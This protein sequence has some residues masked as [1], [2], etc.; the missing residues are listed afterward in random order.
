[1]E[2][3]KDLHLPA[4]LAHYFTHGNWRRT[5][6][7]FMRLA[8][9]FHN[10]W[11]ER[12][13]VTGFGRTGD[14]SRSESGLNGSTLVVGRLKPAA[15]RRSNW[16]R[17]RAVR[18]GASFLAGALVLFLVYGSARAQTEPV[19]GWTNFVGMP[20]GLGSV[21]GTGSSA[22]FSNPY[23]V[24][25]DSAGNVY[26][27]DTENHTIRKVT[28]AGLV[29]TLAG[30]AGQ[31]GSA[32]GTGSAARFYVPDSVAVDS[33]GNVYVADSW[34]ST[35]RK[36]TPAGEVT[37]LAGSAG[38]VGSADGTGSAARFDYPSGV[39]VDNEGNVYAADYYNSTI[40]KVT[41]GGVVTTLAGSA[42]QWGSAD[43]IGSAA[44]FDRP[45]GVAVDSA[46]NV[47]VADMPNCTIR[48]VTAAG[49]VT[50]LAGSPGQ[51]GSAD[52]AG[53]AA[54][55]YFPAG[56]A[57]DS[58]GNV[59]VADY[60]NSTIRKVT[61][62]GVVTTLAGS[63][64]QYGSADGTGRAARFYY[65]SGVAV[66]STG[67]VYV[68]DSL[69]FA[70]PHVNIDRGNSTIRK[71]TPAG[72]VTTLAGSA[73]QYGSADG[74]GSAARFNNPNGVAVDSAG[75]VYVADIFNATIRKVTPAGAV[76][77][78]A[79][80][81]GQVGS[82][83]GIGSAARFYQPT[84]VAVDSAGNVYVA[85]MASSTIRKV[86]PTGVVTT[87]AGSAGQRGSADGAGSEARF[88]N[89]NGV[90]V[91]S[92]GNVYVADMANCTIRK[93]TP[94][95]VVTTIG[96]IPGIID[97]ADG[98]GSAAGFAYPSDIAVDMAGNLYVTDSV[99]NR[100]TKGTP[101]Y[102]QAS[103]SVSPT[104]P[105]AF[106]AIQ[107]G[108][109]ADRSFTIANMGSTIV[110]GFASVAA[111]F[112]IVAGGAYTLSP[113]QSQNVAVR[114]APTAPG[115]HTAY[116]SFA[117]GGGATRQV[118]GSAFNDPTPTTG[119]IAGRVTRSDTHA[120]LNG[121]SIMAIGPGANIFNG[122]SSP[123][124]VT[125]ARAGQAGSFYLAGLA[126]S[127]YYHVLA[128]EPGQKF[129]LAEATGVS[130]VA[131][132]TTTVNIEL[133]PLPGP[134]QP[135]TLTPEQTPVVLV[136]GTGKDEDWSAGESETW[137]AMRSVLAAQGF[138]QIW[139]CN[140]PD[141]DPDF[142]VNNGQGHVINGEQS[143]WW[144]GV[145]LA[146]FIEQKAEQFHRDKGYYPPVI[147]I[148][149]HSM[150]G[151]MTRSAMVGDGFTFFSAT[152][153]WVRVKV[154][155]VV[156]L[157]TP[158][159]GSALADLGISLGNSQFFYQTIGWQPSWPAT[160]D[161]TTHFVRD[162]FNAAHNSWPAGVKLYLAGGGGWLLTTELKLN[163]GGM[164]LAG[165]GG[166]LPP[167]DVLLPPE[168]VNDGAVTWPSLQG[169]FHKRTL[170]LMQLQQYT[171]A[172]LPTAVAPK[173]F[174]T[175]DHSGIKTAAEATAWVIGALRGTVVSSGPAGGDGPGNGSGS[176]PPPDPG[177][178]SLTMQQFEQISATL[179]TGTTN[180]TAI[181]SD[182]A[183]T[184][185]IGLLTGTSN[186]AF[187][188]QTPAGAIIDTNT[189]AANTNVQYS[190]QFGVSNL[191]VMNYT[192]KNPATGVWQAVVDGTALTVTQAVYNLMAFGDSSVALI[193]QMGP[194]FNLGQDVV[195][196][197]GLADLSNSPATP[198][199]NAA[200]TARVQFPNGS[201]TDLTLRDDG[202]HNDGPAGDGIYAALIGGGLPAGDYVVAYR[203]IGTNAQGQPLQRVI[204]GA[205]SI[206]SG[207]GALWGDPVYATVDTN[208]DGFGDVLQIKCWVNPTVAGDYILAGDLVNADGT[209]RFSRSAKFS[210][211]GS[212]AVTVAL[213][214]DLV[215]VRAAAAAAAQGK[216]HLENLSLFEV[217]NTGTAWLDTYRGTSEILIGPARITL[218]LE[219]SVVRLSWPVDC[220]GWEL[221]AQTNSLGVGLG[222]NW[223]A[224]PSS[225]NT[226]QVVM[227]VD[228][229]GTTRFYRLHAR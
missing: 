147:N 79:G 208:A 176:P 73:G 134:S 117:G 139:D 148:V 2:S 101:L 144:N 175:L 166:A 80:S 55:F 44:R 51:R 22:R 132:Q 170:P 53:S 226:T 161:L 40:R 8:G 125:G 199:P 174:S 167:V 19:Y 35:I 110:S 31:F 43:G 221:Q 193:P 122:G 206:S 159:A 149:A 21:D 131:G 182:A 91:D 111:P 112:G 177:T 197:C 13:S 115:T 84:N 183:T 29:T 16:P 104:S 156:M 140:Q 106:G 165:F 205:H 74:T 75:N 67:N 184:L 64:E 76:T 216:F 209:Q 82:A 127:A 163:V 18:R 23:G 190:V 169:K 121:I 7:P 4:L 219:G 145:Q 46:G 151:L 70:K 204:S 223:F 77:T 94:A 130:V 154:N 224:V 191:A 153:G 128:A 56:V 60:Y 90:A 218:G 28:P 33:T 196:D 172:S 229:V 137:E 98:L 72:V 210:A 34:N 192:I 220:L 100:I 49:L 118:T 66:D 102:L 61:A 45:E 146:S 99:N 9:M 50:T 225:T 71:V 185:E 69:C 96:G 83:D 152:G 126:P 113:G 222:T 108:G 95:G 214:L 133:N 228:P 162:T 3:K 200:L 141:N 15:S 89:P 119:A 26:V 54:R 143:I 212:G 14:D 215:E 171:S 6:M 47:Y 201:W 52:G 65:P 138:Q 189:P 203:A 97:G 181:I 178:N 198:V 124:T 158:N 186:V 88:N 25:V 63:A 32:D 187:R 227:P 195:V 107:T 92:A 39:A 217:R 20:G 62:G 38:Q 160:R 87:L 150:G 27:A 85:D 58:D 123:G 157:A 194:L 37:T 173:F 168:Q 1:M 57:V 207:R 48:K 17:F 164:S 5:I 103:L 12:R 179:S 120:A 114:Y 105:L 188:L 129:Y 11:P 42:G 180:V 81:A 135:P 41:A 59:Y 109:T 155:T 116:I 93:V 68:A 211:D 36:V 213:L 10:R 30:S 24:A 136:R 86:A 78:L 142:P 202:L